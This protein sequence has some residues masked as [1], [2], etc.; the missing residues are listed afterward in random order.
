[1]SSSSSD[2]DV[3]PVRKS[4][5]RVKNV[6]EWKAVVR[7]RKRVSGEEHVSKRNKLVAGKRMGSPC[8][9][10]HNPKCFDAVGAAH[11][12]TI[13]NNY[14]ELGNHL[15]FPSHLDGHNTVLRP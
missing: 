10:Y 13:F 7:K 14:Y 11:V 15:S 3:E 12:N 5:K 1:M 2:S 6:E 4:R 8:R 9:C